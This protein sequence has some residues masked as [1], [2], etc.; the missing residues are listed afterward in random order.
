MKAKSLEEKRQDKIILYLLERNRVSDTEKELFIKILRSKKG[1]VLKKGN[2]RRIL[3]GYDF[4]FNFIGY[5]TP[6]KS[7]EV[8]F[9]DV[10]EFLK[11]AKKASFENYSTEESSVV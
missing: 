1:Q 11:W 5:T 8:T 3:Y 4:L 6:R 2:T 10:D 7:K 9:I